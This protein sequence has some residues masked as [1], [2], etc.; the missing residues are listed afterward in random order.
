MLH[1]II[2]RAGSGKTRYITDRIS[3]CLDAGLDCLYIVPEQQS[4]DAELMLENCGAVS[5]NAEVLNFERLPDHIFRQVGGCANKPLD[6]AACFVCLADAIKQENQRLSAYANPSAHNI[7]ALAASIS[8][9]K[10][11]SV[12]PDGFESIC[13]KMKI[14]FGDGLWTKLSEL[15]IIYRKYEEILGAAGIDTDDAPTLLCRVLETEPFFRGKAVFL[16]GMYTYTEQQYEIIRHIANQAEEF[17]VTFTA[18]DNAGGIFDGINEAARRI[19][20][21]AGGVCRDVVLPESHRSEN[22]ALRFLESNIWNGNAIFDEAADSVAFYRCA[23][24]HDE[25]LCAAA[26]IYAL[27]E[28]GLRFGDI[29]IACRDPESYDGVLDTVFERYNIPFYF[30]KKESAATKPLAAFISGILEMAERGCTLESVKKYIKSSFSVLTRAEGDEILS[31]AEGWRIRGKAWYGER[32]WLMN[33]DGY[34]ED[35]TP[36]QELRLKKINVLR[37]KFALSVAPVIETLQDKNLTVET[38]VRCLYDHMKDC[39]VKSKLAGAAEKL[40]AAG[41]ADEAKKLVRLWGVFTDIFDRLYS[42]SGAQK[43]TVG[44]LRQLM[45]LMLS[46]YDIGAIPSYTDAV[47]IGSARLMRA[48][49]VKAM[50]VLGINDGA[51]P[52][53]PE[54]S[55]IF[56]AEESAVIEQFGVSFLPSPEKAMNEECFFFYNCV[57]APTD[58]LALSYTFGNG[59]KPSVAFTTVAS[60]FPLNA[61]RRFGEDERDYMFCLRSAADRLPYIKNAKLKKALSNR[62][63]EAGYQITVPAPLQDENAYI[64]ELDVRVLVLSA[65]KLETYNNCGF[66]YLTQY[67]L[68]LK[69]ERVF[70]FNPTNY[71]TFLHYIVE[72]FVKK[73]M[74]SGAF[75]SADEKECR[76]EI[77]AISSGYFDKMFPDGLPKRTELLIDRLKNSAFY[78]C[79]SLNEEF[80]VSSFVPEGFEVSIGMGG[81][82]PP[83]FVTDS[84]KKITTQGKIDRVD[85]AVIDGKRYVRVVDYKTSH[86]KFSVDAVENGENIQ[87]LS[88]LFAY[89]EAEKDTLPAGVLYRPMELPDNGTESPQ[90]GVVLT[91]ND[92]RKK[93]DPYNKFTQKAKGVTAEELEGLRE[94][95]YKHIKETGEHILCG[96]MGVK[97]FKLEER[98][99]VFCPF[100][101]VCRMKKPN[102]FV[103]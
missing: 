31:Y 19:K 71:G 62:L 75:I 26:Q 93:M 70:N 68:K 51:F 44:E 9:L 90:E 6:K 94:L 76:V 38:A 42:L 81:V 46:G 85:S 43:C 72:H 20:T 15:A 25:A 65:T 69:R 5:L 95:V 36:N 80:S 45:E 96:D 78:I 101:E 1:R 102:P 30:S 63:E 24:R 100:G 28:K 32:D 12:T 41:D 16:D 18:D 52:S 82:T 11:L 27:R 10:R 47:D 84:G 34:Q 88:Y 74:E 66:R 29:A 49:G 17:Y 23:D 7:S 53:M 99:C 92:V 59:E 79:Q 64:G 77:D 14:G 13:A 55:G 48:G 67:I 89:C 58:Y 83:V 98:E 40:D 3:E 33:P 56:S 21:L 60:M 4:M 2:G 73:R 8:A 87:M 54:K 22:N 61:V 35:F 97:P 39:D 50:I 37:E 103:N 91:E 57:A 86:K